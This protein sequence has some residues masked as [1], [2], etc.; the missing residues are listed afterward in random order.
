[1][2]VFAHCLAKLAL[3]DAIPHWP[4]GPKIVKKLMACVMNGGGIYTFAGK[5]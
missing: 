4:E 5:L 2:T 3:D 1:M